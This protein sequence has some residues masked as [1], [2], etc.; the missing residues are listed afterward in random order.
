MSCSSSERFFLKH[1][2]HERERRQRMLAYG[3]SYV[4]ILVTA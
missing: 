1:A 3:K 4:Q 2:P